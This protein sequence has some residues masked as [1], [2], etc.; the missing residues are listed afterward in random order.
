MSC[1]RHFKALSVTETD[2]RQ[3]SLGTIFGLISLK[4]S[5]GLRPPNPLARGS[6][7]GPHWGLRPQTPAAAIS[8]ALRTAKCAGAPR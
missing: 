8:A 2:Y 4:K 1:Y 6:A 7:P 3:P 5:G